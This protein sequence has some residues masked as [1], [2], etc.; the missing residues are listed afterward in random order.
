MLALKSIDRL[1]C[2]LA[3][4]TAPPCSAVPMCV[5][6]SSREPLGVEIISSYLPSGQVFLPS[7]SSSCRLFLP[8]ESFFLQSLSSWHLMG[9]RAPASQQT[10]LLRQLSFVHSL[11]R[12]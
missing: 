2:P 10:R 5:R 8:A 7:D 3:I 4:Q 9:S 6:P 11:A 1:R 12:P